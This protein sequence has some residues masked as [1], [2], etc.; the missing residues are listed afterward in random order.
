MLMDL[1]KLA[2]HLDNKG[3]KREADYLDVVIRKM[4]EEPVNT[5]PVDFC[6]LPPGPWA[7]N[8]SNTYIERPTEEQRKILMEMNMSR[9]MNPNIGVTNAPPDGVSAEEHCSGKFSDE[10]MIYEHGGPSD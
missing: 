1:I 6:N 2:T 10:Y 4:A 8:A 3:F 7:M 9:A 5:D